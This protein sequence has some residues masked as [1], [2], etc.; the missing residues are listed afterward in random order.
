VEA[1]V[2]SE[3]HQRLV[4]GGCVHLSGPPD[5]YVEGDHAVAV[6]HSLLILHRD[7]RFVI[8][9]AGAN[10]WQL[11]REDGEWRVTVRTTRA[12]DGSVKARELFRV[13]ALERR[14]E[15]VA[16]EELRRPPRPADS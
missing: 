13:T 14:T 2:E 8:Y 16:G 6:C 7:G 3:P 10:H 11:R 9:R 15:Q 4:R 12:L 5:V 1:M